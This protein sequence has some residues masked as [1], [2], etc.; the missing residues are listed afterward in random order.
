MQSTLFSD[1][2]SFAIQTALVHEYYRGLWQV[3]PLAI[4]YVIVQIYDVCLTL[5]LE[6]TF[7]WKSP[8]S[9]TKAL[10]LLTRYLPFVDVG[11]IAI[12]VAGGQVI[13]SLRTWAFWRK[14]RYI[15][16]ILSFVWVIVCAIQLGL[17][18]Y[19]A[20]TYKC[21]KFKSDYI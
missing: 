1:Q 6:I 7:I 17:A 12:G 9:F 18:G 8:G 3:A 21:K 11:M 16:V 19:Q 5:D 4:L 15:L 20:L 2:G 10:Y 14:Q 13:L